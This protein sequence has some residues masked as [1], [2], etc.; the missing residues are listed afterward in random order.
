LEGNESVLD[1]GCGGGTGSRSLA[2]LLNKGGH[3]TCIDTSGYWIAKAQKRLATFSNA[4]CRL[5]DIRELDIPDSSFDIISTIH[6]V[7][8]IAP[9]DRSDIVE[10][11]SR[12][13]RAGGLFFIRE[14]T[15]K[16]HGTPV[17]EIR[18]LLSRADMNEIRHKET[19][20]EYR[21][22]YRRAH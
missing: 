8:D 14:F 19:R 18:S 13:L 4:E 1:F 6:V 7:H 10:T 17:D 12:K 21:G 16:S 2:K 3:L 20:S 5:G 11:L 9:A 22:K 15:R